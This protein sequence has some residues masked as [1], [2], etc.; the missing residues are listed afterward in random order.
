MKLFK[1]DGA[2]EPAAPIS[3]HFL[4]FYFILIL[5]ILL[6]FTF[7]PNCRCLDVVVVAAAAA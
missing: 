7:C 6:L 1:W 2:R 3:T 5:F 4:A